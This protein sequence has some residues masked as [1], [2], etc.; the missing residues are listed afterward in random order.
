MRPTQP[1]L[2]RRCAT[3]CDVH[4]TPGGAQAPRR[5]HDGGIH[6]AKKEYTTLKPGASNRLHLVP[7]TS[8]YPQGA[9]QTHTVGQIRA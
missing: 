6:P 5:G 7:P 9:S 2:A 3:V 1:R 4:P 8:G